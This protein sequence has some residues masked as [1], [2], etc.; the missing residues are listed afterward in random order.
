MI[1]LKDNVLLERDLKFEDIKPRLLGE[2]SIVISLK[3]LLILLRS[4]GHMSR[5]D[6]GV[7]PLELLDSKGG[8]KHG[9]RGRTRS[10]CSRNSCVVM[11]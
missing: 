11:D 4:L 3:Y 2:C 1:F 10:R 9:L 6:P 7:L 5:P 8:P